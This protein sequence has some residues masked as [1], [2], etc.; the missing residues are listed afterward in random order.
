MIDS[1]TSR[2]PDFDKM[3]AT[4]HSNI[5]TEQYNL[6]LTSFPTLLKT[7]SK[8]GH[9]P[10]SV[11]A[12]LGFNPD[13]DTDGKEVHFLHKGEEGECSQREKCLTHKYQQ[14]QRTNKLKLIEAKKK[15]VE[16]DDKEKVLDILSLNTECETKLPYLNNAILTDFSKLTVK[17]LKPFILARVPEEKVGSI[18]KGNVADA[19]TGI[20]NLIVL[21]FDLKDKEVKL[22]KA[23][24]EEEM[25]VLQCEESQG[26]E[27]KTATMLEIDSGSCQFKCYEESSQLL[28]NKG[29][30]KCVTEV[31]VHGIKILIDVNEEIKK[32]AN[33][34][35]R[36]LLQQLTLHV[37]RCVLLALQ[38][39]TAWAFDFASANISRMSTII[40]LH[41]HVKKDLM[42]L[43]I[44][45]T[46]LASDGDFLVCDDDVSNLEG[47]YG[48]FNTNNL[49]HIQSG[50][51]TGRLFFICNQEHLKAA[52]EGTDSL[53]YCRY[54]S[55]ESSVDEGRKGSF[56]NLL[57]LV[58]FAYDTKFERLDDSLKEL[59]I[60]PP[61]CMKKMESIRFGRPRNV[62]KIEIKRQHM[63]S[64]V[65]ELVY[66]I[67]ICAADNVSQSPGFK[68][69]GLWKVLNNFASKKLRSIFIVARRLV[70]QISLLLFSP[71]T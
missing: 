43:S 18:R 64:Y 46:L 9:I 54:P 32:Q 13:V 41:N 69:C 20:K 65:V 40:C 68:S 37:R 33:Q 51:M 28:T 71:Q 29:W 7:F 27:D 67:A 8:K 49:I 4:C 56:K 60:F 53:F 57:H 35:Q 3:L 6:C 59:F 14:Q 55:S 31:T 23:L 25:V 63:I 22:E 44:E 16:A 42:C 26:Q 19:E 66:D 21:A 11:F 30:L 12:E 24:E 1:G 10:D 47:T 2:Y 50:K 58:Y 34:L 5:S 48:Y 62:M 39:Q 52:K 61:A 17:F 70:K 15:R 45:K 38:Q 36:L